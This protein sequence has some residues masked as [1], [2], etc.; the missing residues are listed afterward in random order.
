[1]RRALVW[2]RN[3]LRTTDHPGFT[4]CSDAECLLPLYIYPERFFST[5][6]FGF[7]KTGPF[8]AAFLIESVNELRQS[9]LGRGSDLLVCRGEPAAIIPRL[10][11]LYRLDELWY[12][13]E[14]GTEEAEEAGAVERAV[15]MPFPAPERLSP[16]PVRI[17]DIQQAAGTSA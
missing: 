6:S 7:A 17:E 12:Q 2:F 8:R 11:E 1:M 16:L 4:A 13:E 14:P 15:R 10:A 9:L 3:D 5:T